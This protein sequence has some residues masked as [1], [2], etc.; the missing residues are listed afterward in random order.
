VL[1]AFLV[2][3]RLTT[4][5]ARERKRQVVLRFLAATDFEEDR[6][7]PERDVDMRLALRHR[8]VAAL[9]RYLVDGRYLGREAGIYRRRPMTDWPIDP[10]EA[11]LDQPLA[12]RSPEE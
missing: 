10:D 1:H 12:D 6:D 7:Y 8:D 9:R 5:P 2:D 11:S 4:I 3:G